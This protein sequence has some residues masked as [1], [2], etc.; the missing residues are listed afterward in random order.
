MS[1]ADERFPHPW[2]MRGVWLA[3]GLGTLTRIAPLFDQGGRLLRQFPTEDGYLMLTIA[4]N[5]AIGHGMSTS[6]GTIP[7]NGTQPLFNLV[8][9][10]LFWLVNGDKRLGVLLTLVTQVFVSMWGAW[11]LYRL[12][13]LVL[14]ERPTL[15]R[16]VPPLAAALWYASS[17]NVP[18][19]MN[20]LETALYGT[21]ILESLRR[22]YAM[23]LERRVDGA[24]LRGAVIVGLWLGATFWAR[25][26][27]VFLIAAIT[28][29]NWLAG[30]RLDGR[31][32][33]LRRFTES[34][35]MGATAIGVASP[36]LINNLLRFGSVMP[37]SG[38]AQSK[39]TT[40]GMA[41]HM[42]PPKLFECFW[43]I[44]P[45]PLQI[46]QH[47]AVW[48]GTSI[49]VLAYLAA[50]GWLAR[51]MRAEEKVFFAAVA[52]MGLALIS[53]Y[54]LIFGAPHFF[55][56]Y[57]FPLA[58]FSAIT[59]SIFVVVAVSKG[60]TVRPRLA[61]AA[62]VLALSLLAVADLRL[63]LIGEDHE[64]AQVVDWV[65]EHVDEGTWVGAIQTGTLG[66]F[67]DR[68]VNLD[69]K[70]N[71]GA[72]AAKLNGEVDQY[73]VTEKFGPEQGRIDY[74]VD[75]ISITQWYRGA[76]KHHFDLVVAD[77]E[78]NLG[79]MRRRT[80]AAHNTHA[81]P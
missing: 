40:F 1:A 47:P 4:R 7:T 45:V 6:A 19:T 56:R 59:T 9:A 18:H 76:L 64:H 27:A 5:L 52:T 70:V 2:F 73:V 75:W 62:G 81:S 17:I 69:G 37:I 71:P 13:K 31:H 20:C 14:R 29:C 48:G 34:V 39:L 10:A 24:S 51:H 49:A 33:G 67:H 50:L 41:L 79:V 11:A 78:R 66:F 63:Y 77:R 65:S 35:V 32:S 53:Y 55:N 80:L 42:L 15:V 74:V 25:I 68:T 21:L 38:T 23:F 22:W 36:W 54:G 60:P 58:G 8:E 3:F 44:V 72:L 46:E 16:Y 30:M 61:M 28:G 57:M 43:L 12:A 26:D